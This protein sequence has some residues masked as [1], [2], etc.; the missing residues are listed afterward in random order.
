MT[1]SRNTIRFFVGLRAAAVALAAMVAP[2]GGASGQ[3]Q[4]V[5]EGRVVERGTT[6][7]I[8]GASVELDGYPITSTSATGTFRLD[9]VSPGGYDL[10]VEAFGYSPHD[11]FLVI[12]RDTTVLIELEVAPVVLDTLAVDARKIGIRGVVVDRQSEQRLIRTEIGTSLN[13]ETRTNGAGRFRLRDVPAGFPVQVRLRAFGYLPL[14]ST[15]IA[16]QDT[17]MTFAMEIDSLAQRMIGVAVGRLEE[18]SRPFRSAIMPPIGRE[19]LLRNSNATVLD[20]LKSRYSINLRRIQCILI[21]DRQTYN[22]LDE[23]AVILPEELERIEVLERGRMLR[24][25]TRNF[26]KR[27]LGGGVQ[28]V[29][30]LYVEFARPPVCR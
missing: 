22:G 21:D 19:E 4:V 7:P 20:V 11:V 18:R 17:S 3:T 2:G 16:E 25:Y 12:R 14:D 23:M 13:H 30:P 6:V 15:I 28:L 8:A 9:G 5:I 24:L 10:R 26:I 27:M 29:R 1:G